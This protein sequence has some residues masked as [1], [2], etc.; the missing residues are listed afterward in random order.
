[1][2]STKGEMPPELAR[3]ISSP[4]GP[5]SVSRGEGEI[6]SRF[7]R[8]EGEILGSGKGMLATP[9]EGKGHK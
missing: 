5:L 7:S 1:M 6:L 2:R 9:A 8:G 4:P 3:T